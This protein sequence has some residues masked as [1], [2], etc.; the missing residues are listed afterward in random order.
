MKDGE[1]NEGPKVS[2]KLRKIIM[3]NA[4]DLKEI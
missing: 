3:Y 1:L 2:I 4:L